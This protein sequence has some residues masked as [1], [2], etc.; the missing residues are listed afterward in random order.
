MWRL[1]DRSVRR[2]CGIPRAGRSILEAAILD[3]Q[4]DVIPGNEP[5][6]VGDDE[7][8]TVGRAPALAQELDDPIAAGAVE[9]AGRFVGLDHNRVMPLER[10]KSQRHA[11]TWMVSPR[12][13]KAARDGRLTRLSQAKDH[14]VASPVALPRWRRRSSG[15]LPEG[16]AP[17]NFASHA[18]PELSDFSS[19][20]EPPARVAG[21]S[22]SGTTTV[23][24]CGTALCEGNERSGDG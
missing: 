2:A 3:L 19:G 9:V 10:L 22:A 4:H 24:I 23:G 12:T 21:A 18:S 5:A 7:Q 6:V 11:S 8:G 16:K 20:G 13:A 15:I 17:T 1:T 14:I